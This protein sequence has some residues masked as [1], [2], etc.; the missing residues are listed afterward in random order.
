VKRLLI[1]AATISLG[2]ASSAR[3]A[4]TTFNINANGTKEVNASGVP[5][6]D[7]DGSIVGTLTLDPGTGGNT[8]SATFNLV[9][10]NVDFPLTAWHIH[11]GAPTTAG[12]VFIGFA[13]PATFRNG[14]LLTGTSGGLST[15]NINLVLSNPSG[16]Y[17]NTHNGP[18]PGGAVRDQ[19]PEPGALSL[20]GIAGLALLRRRRPAA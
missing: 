19:L 2:I 1:A 20:I 13:N 11:S 3:A 8:G 18:F 10:T 17:F 9:V 14:N 16:Y 4:T 6:G 15:D 5:N 7:P 12:P